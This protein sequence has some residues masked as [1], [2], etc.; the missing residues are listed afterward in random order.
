MIYNLGHSDM[1]KCIES[2]R[3]HVKDSY[4]RAVGEEIG[5]WF[6]ET[7]DMLLENEQLTSS[8]VR[9]YPAKDET[10]YITVIDSTLR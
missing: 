3:Q 2:Y 8:K 4:C 7:M 1:P 9:F 10:S 5:P 6:D